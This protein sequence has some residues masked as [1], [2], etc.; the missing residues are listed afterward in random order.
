LNAYQVLGI[1]PGADEKTIKSAY[2]K[3]AMQHH[4]DRN[5]D[6]E[7]S[8]VKFREIQT[9]YETL[10]KPQPQQQQHHPFGDNPFGPGFTWHF[11][12]FAPP[13]R[14]NHDSQVRVEITLEQAYAGHELTFEVD[15]RIVTLSIPKGIRE[16]QRLRV[17]GEGGRQ[18]S[19]LPPGD[20]Y[21]F[22]VFETHERF[23][24][25][26]GDLL[27]VENV[28]VLDLVLGT[29]V[30][31]MTIAGT[32]VSV[33]IPAGTSHH[34]RLRV[35]GRGMPKREGG[36]FDLFI[37]INPTYPKLSPEQQERLRAVRN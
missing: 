16:G 10:T 13:P 5:G 1:D 33:T 20:L 9:A 30:D 31:V 37:E 19:D 14:Q 27:V 22:V 28:D 29:K 8:K 17:E 3:L 15:N 26:G 6:S 11:Q 18:F 23:A 32:T 7:E 35:P 21:V 4:P 24:Y 2:R 34:T 36:S 25:G 12:D